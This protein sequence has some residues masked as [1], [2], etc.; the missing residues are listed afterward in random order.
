[1]DKE[2]SLIC[3]GQVTEK[4]KCFAG[5]TNMLKN[6]RLGQIKQ[7]RV[8]CYPIDNV[9]IYLSN[10]IKKCKIEL[11]EDSF[12]IF[13]PT[14]NYPSHVDE[15]GVSYFVPLEGGLFFIDGVSY[16]VVPFVLYGFDDGKL[17]NS[18]FGSIMIK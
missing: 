5:L 7:S 12:E 13:V 15:G 9:P 16:P 18:N 4:F 6:I 3:Y 14:Q 10:K 11:I 8:D 2:I 17:H 1:M